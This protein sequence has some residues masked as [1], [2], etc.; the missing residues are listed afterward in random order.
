MAT[1]LRNRIEKA[2]REGVAAR[3]EYYLSIDLADEQKL[4]SPAAATELRALEAALGKPLPP[5][6][7]AFLELHDGWKMVDGAVDLL[8]VADLLGGSRRSE[9]ADWQQRMLAAGDV[10]AGQALVIGVSD[11]TPTRY[12]LDPSSIDSDGEW[13]FVQHH[14]VEEAELPSFIV[15]LEESVD[16]YLQLA[17]GE[18]DDT[19][20]D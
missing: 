20:P 14:N 17:R 13:R 2:V 7:R 19:D 3:H 5:S 10:V 9:I 11:V 8:A 15:W 12:L 16:E 18:V 6:Y 1:T 4:G